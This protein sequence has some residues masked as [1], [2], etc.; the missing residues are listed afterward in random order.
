[1]RHFIGLETIKRILDGMAFAKLNVLHWGLSNYQ[2]FRVESHRFP[3]LHTHASNGRFYTQAEVRELI[4]YAARRGIR[5]VPEFNMPGHSTAFLVACPELAAHDP[6]SEPYHRFSIIDDVMDPTKDE[7]F[8]FIHNFVEEFAALFPD[9]HWHMGGDE[10]M[11][12]YW[13]ENPT[14][15]AY[16]KAEGLADNAALQA[17]F[18]DRY[19]AI[20]RKA[21]KVPI[22]WEEVV[23]GA[24]DPDGLMVESWIGSDDCSAYET[25]S[26]TGFYLDHFLTAA[27]HYRIDPQAYG[28]QGGEAAVWTEAMMDETVENYIWPRAGAIAERLWS[29]KECTDERDLYRR[30]SGFDAQLEAR[31]AHHHQAR[32]LVLDRAAGGKADDQWAVLASGLR[33]T[34]YYFLR[35]EGYDCATPADRLVQALDPDPPAARRFNQGVEDYLATGTGR[36]SLEAGLNS[37]LGAA[38]SVRLPY[39]DQPIAEALAALCELGIGLL[40]GTPGLDLSVLARIE[41][42]FPKSALVPDILEAIF[43][44]FGEAD[45][46]LA[47]KHMNLAI[48]PGVKALA[49]AAESD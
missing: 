8:A 5:V 30:L 21:D 1:M 9:S 31:G 40:R 6:P 13:D 20:L 12:K 32:A 34:A 3:R 14:I 33:P 45:R 4:G 11:G 36:G 39:D 15:Q 44:V 37:W 42:A 48:W 49:D 16:M 46:P 35:W 7:V 18:T 28:T 38:R 17:R 26:A 25:I 47:L 2:G 27:D 19:A 24:P 22:G 23:R 10:V 43:R 41:P 29:P